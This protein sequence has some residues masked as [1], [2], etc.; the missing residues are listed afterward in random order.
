MKEIYSLSETHIH[1]VDNVDVHNDLKNTKVTNLKKI[2]SLVFDPTITF[3]VNI[4][5]KTYLVTKMFINP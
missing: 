4:K 1:I 2:A 5:L 3:M